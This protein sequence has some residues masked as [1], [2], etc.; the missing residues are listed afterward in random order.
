MGDYLQHFVRL[1]RLS[2]PEIEDIAQ[3]VE[4]WLLD[5]GAIQAN[6]SL[7]TRWRLRPWVPGPRWGDIVM[8]GY[9]S[10]GRGVLVRR[11]RTVHHP[12]ENFEAPHCGQCSG[13]LSGDVY[14]ATMEVWLDEEE[15]WQVCQGCGWGALIGDW[16]PAGPFQFVIGAPAI[17][18]D[19][20]PSLTDAFVAEV[21]GRLGG[22]A[23]LVYES[24]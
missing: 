11:D 15:P 14:Q 7:H 6:P 17:V 24:C 12:M 21:L 13:E 19:N 1:D 8:P 5:L 16:P 2:S 22:R 9:D 20:W 23:R 4:A 10:P 18:F 3:S